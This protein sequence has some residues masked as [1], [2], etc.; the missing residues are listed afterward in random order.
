MKKYIL[1]I[2]AIMLAVALAFGVSAFKKS[3]ADSKNKP[4]TDYYYEF[5]GTHGHE[6]DMSLWN[7]LP[8]L[9]DYNDYNCINGTSNSCKIINTTNSGSHPTAVPLDS[10]GFPVKGTVNTDVKLKQ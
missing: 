7:Q 5:S 2:C 6:S 3:K 4:L 10:N 1:S 9:N 8:S